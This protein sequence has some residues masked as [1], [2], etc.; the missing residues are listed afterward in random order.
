MLVPLSWLKDHVEIDFS[1]DNLGEMLTM[2]GLETEALHYRGKGIEDIVIAKIL[3]IKNHPNAD[4]LN[5]CEVTDGME[6]YNIVCGADNFGVNDYVALARSGAKLPPTKKF[7]EGLKIKKTK[8][9][10]ETSQGM[11]C[12]EDELGLSDRSDGIMVLSSDLSLGSRLVDEMSLNGAVLK[13]Q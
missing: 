11:L 13:L 8:I 7:P 10:G 2:A 1:L 3:E 6:N 12:A 4:R 9:R 5:V